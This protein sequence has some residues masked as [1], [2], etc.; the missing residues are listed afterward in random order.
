[1]R[2]TMHYNMQGFFPLGGASVVLLHTPGQFIL[3]DLIVFKN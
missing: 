2:Q 1:M 3:H